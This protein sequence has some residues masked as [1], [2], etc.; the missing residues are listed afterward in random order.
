MQRAPMIAPVLEIFLKKEKTRS[1]SCKCTFIPETKN[2]V[3]RF[4][5][6]SIDLLT[7]ISVPLLAVTVSP[8]K[9]MS[10]HSYICFP[11]TLLANRR[12][13]MADEKAII[14][15]S[16]INKKSILRGI[17]LGSLNTS[18]TPIW[19][20]TRIYANTTVSILKHQKNIFIRWSVLNWHITSLL[21]QL[22]QLYF[23]KNSCDSNSGK[24]SSS[25]H[26]LF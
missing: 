17:S 4:F 5:A 6:V 12:G 10:Y 18:P 25:R 13:S 24:P 26:I 1:F 23:W 20:T 7:T 15:N 22:R 8:S 19:L 3:F 11:L 14:E 9:L 2:T 16:S 21:K